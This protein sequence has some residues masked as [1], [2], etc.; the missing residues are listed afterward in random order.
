MHADL[1]PVGIHVSVWISGRDNIDRWMF[2]SEVLGPVHHGGV[3]ECIYIYFQTLSFGLGL[4]V[5]FLVFG[6]FAP[7]YSLGA[8]LR[9]LLG[10][11]SFGIIVLST[12][13]CIE[14]Q[15]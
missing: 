1:Y 3:S 2:G 6:L 5:R 14:V 12:C 11:I 13:L 9:R 10:C 7:S 4:G 8:F 15:Y